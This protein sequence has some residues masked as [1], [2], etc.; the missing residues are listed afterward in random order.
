[1]VNKKKNP[2]ETTNKNELN[3]YS[4]C[5]TDQDVFNKLEGYAKNR[6]KVPINPRA[7]YGANPVS[8][9]ITRSDASEL[10]N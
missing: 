8:N 9:K 4:D 6:L 10:I 3:V 1:M 7:D 2:M 5:I